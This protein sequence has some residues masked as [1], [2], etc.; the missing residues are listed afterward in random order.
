MKLVANAALSNIEE[1]ASHGAVKNIQWQQNK[2]AR[3]KSSGEGRN[4]GV[5]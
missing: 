4:K 1:M 2:A 5:G 3:K